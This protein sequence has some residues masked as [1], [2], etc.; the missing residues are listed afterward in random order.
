MKSFKARIII[1]L[2]ISALITSPI[3]AQEAIS[4]EN[5][6]RRVEKERIQ[7]KEL[8]KQNPN[9]FGNI[10]KID[11][12]KNFPVQQYPVV[13]PMK[14]NTKYEKLL[15]VGLYPEDNVLEAVIEVKLPY[16]FK[17]GLCSKGSKEYV[18]FY[19]D[20]RD[21]NGFV[22]VGAPA[23]VSVHNLNFI[24]KRHVFYA[25]RKSFIPKQLIKCDRPQL[26]RVRAILSWEKL[27]TGPNY[28]PPWGNVI[29]RWVQI[30][31]RKKSIFTPVFPG[32]VIMV[33]PITDYLA[34][35]VIKEP[36]KGPFP[37]P[38]EPFA[39]IEKYMIM[40]DM[41]EI[42]ELVGKTIRAEERIREERTVG[43]DRLDFNKHITANPN[44]FG[45]IVKSK[46][47]SDVMEAVA[48]LPEKTIE[49]LLPKLAINPNL[50]IPVN[51]SLLKTKY[52]QLTCVGLYPE[53][54]LLEA[55]IEVKLP[56]G[57]SGDLCTLGS[58]EYVAF[59]IDWGGG[60]QYIATAT[61]GV[62]DIPGINERRHLFYA[63]KTNIPD[64]KLKQ[65]LC[66]YEN[67]VKVKAILSWNQNPTPYGPYFKPTWGNVLT[68]YIQ[69]R[70]RNGASA[71]C[72]IDIVNEVH[73]DNIDNGLAVKIASTYPY[74]YD[75]P[76]GGIIACKG[77]VKIYGA[78]YYRFKYS[79][80]G[81]SSWAFIKDRRRAKNPS[82][83]PIVYVNRYPDSKGW[84]STSQ[85]LSDKAQYDSTALVHWRSYGK[86]GT[87]LLRLELGDAG[88]NPISGQ[89]DDVQLI[90]DN[91]APELL[92]FGGTPLPTQ[93]VSV[94]DIN[95]NFKKCGIFDANEPIRIFGNFK[96]DY[97]SQCGLL[98]FG[99]NIAASGHNLISIKYDSGHAAINN[100]GIKL[101]FNY[102]PGRE[103]HAF[104]L[105]PIP[106]T[107]GKI[108]CAYGIRLSVSDRAIVGSVSGYE[109]NTYNHRRSA[110]VTFDW[111]PAGCP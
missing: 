17:G 22:S 106:Q 27:P 89:K 74:K 45:S 79:T 47:S 5:T 9:Y 53:D 13:F 44:Y 63:V 61:V 8:I 4:R 99:G 102:G 76:F 67:I 19:I 18:G 73:V 41:D 78:K 50:L 11:L 72:E 55:V 51:V 16:G 62:H 104:D 91:T 24:N 6:I 10:S 14:Y 60:F 42:K 92:W 32:K 25:V 66:N 21:G 2:F 88:K 39:P 107:G 108:K 29:N 110:F 69:I 3:W 81:G 20:Y 64:K 105:C 28:N 43:P 77:D 68:K 37:P 70:P 52:E 87:Y 46:K 82:G 23:E 103:L 100:K 40:G 101:A 83:F 30:K 12:G 26:V 90:L 58:T 56:N 85:Y 71:K 75:R 1:M 98:V 7:F 59:Y 94:K 80:D 36:P 93:G 111:D 48:K 54:D 57:F 97:F 95:S 86:N 65:K 31:P 38:P 33:D 34:A 96:D 35:E 109:F 84:F 15:C 49:S